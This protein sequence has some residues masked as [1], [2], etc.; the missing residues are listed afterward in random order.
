MSCGSCCGL[1]NIRELSRERLHAILADRTA[2]FASVPRTIDTILAFETGRMEQEGTDYP[3]ENFHHC[4][5]VGLI[6]DHG[7]RVGCM[8]HP[9]AHGNG[10][11]DWRGL[12]HYG[13]A[14]CKHFF[15]P[16]YDKL[17]ADRKRLVRTLLGDW[18]EYGLIIPEHRFLTALL[19]ILEERCGR[20]LDARSLEQPA[21]KAVA[22]LL[23]LRL[24]WPF[25]DPEAPKAWNFFSTRETERPGLSERTALNDP[26]VLRILHELDTAR[27]QEEPAAQNLAELIDQAVAVIGAK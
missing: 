7:E 27:D 22:D 2:A 6:R 16:T 3:I 23:R 15:C 5:F 12:S 8:L 9:L 25:R 10:G 14:A 17:E 13:G 1:Y 20:A 19:D 26:R 11:V 4:V 21:R 18:Y 24:D